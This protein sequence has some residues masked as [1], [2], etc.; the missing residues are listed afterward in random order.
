MITIQPYQK[1]NAVELNMTRDMVIHTLGNPDKQVA[2]PNQSARLFW[3]EME[4]EFQ[5]NNLR[6]V[7]FDSK[8]ELLLD[9]NRVSLFDTDTLQKENP[10]YQDNTYLFPK[11]GLMVYNV[12]NYQNGFEVRFFSPLFKDEF[13]TEKMSSV[14][15]TDIHRKLSDPHPLFTIKPFHAVGPLVFGMNPKEVESLIGKP[16][17]TI[18]IRG[19]LREKRKN[20]N[21]VYNNTGK[22]IQVSFES[23]NGIFYEGVD[24]S[25]TG[26]LTSLFT[27]KEAFIN[28]SYTIFFDIGVAFQN[29]DKKGIKTIVVF[30]EEKVSFWK[31]L[32]MPIF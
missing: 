29:F 23:F 32:H 4:I 13:S 12:D 31:N 25:Q 30:N 20:I 10:H 1:V 24:I 18:T 6:S 8:S 2:G 15:Y 26:H 27:D 22:L 7:A 17:D 21:T 3:G 5:G 14:R 16:L 9:G 19:E 11:W 28:R